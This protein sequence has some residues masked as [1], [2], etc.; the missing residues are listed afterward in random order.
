VKP[1]ELRERY[2]RLSYNGQNQAPGAT[3]SSDS[4]IDRVMVRPVAGEP[5]NLALS[6]C[7]RYRNPGGGLTK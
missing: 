5:L 4:R 6:T 3:A 1:R 2:E 7:I